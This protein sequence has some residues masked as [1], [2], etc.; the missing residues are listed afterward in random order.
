MSIFHQWIPCPWRTFVIIDL[1]FPLLPAMCIIPSQTCSN[2]AQI[3]KP[4]FSMVTLSLNFPVR[5]IFSRISFSHNMAQ[6]F[7]LLH[8]DW[9]QK[10]PIS[11]YPA[12]YFFTGDQIYP[13]DMQHPS[14]EP[15]ISSLKPLVHGSWD[16]LTLTVIYLD[17]EY[18]AAKN[19]HFSF[20]WKI[21]TF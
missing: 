8:P 16:S 7:Q 5:T 2:A 17:G 10:N 18:I 19:S 1:Q 13:W 9:R 20:N 21:P 14:V 4:L 11:S 12:Q 3:C 15:H 6:K